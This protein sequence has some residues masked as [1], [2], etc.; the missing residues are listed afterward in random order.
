MIERLQIMLLAVVL[1]VACGSGDRPAGGGVGLADVLPESSVTGEWRAVDGPTSYDPE[2]LYEYL[3]GGAPL[4][5]AHGFQQLIHVRYQRGDDIMS[6]V[7][8]TLSTKSMGRL[9]AKMCVRAL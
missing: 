9:L 5:L 3:N 4:Y 8:L 1:A 2:T 7:A 6:S